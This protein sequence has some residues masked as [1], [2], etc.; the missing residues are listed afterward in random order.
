[1]LEVLDRLK[2]TVEDFAARSDKL[3]EEFRARIDRERQ[4][5]EAALAEQTQQ[6]AAASSAADSALQTALD[7]AESKFERRKSVIGKAY[8]A[9][10][11]Q[12]LKDIEKKTGGRKYELQKTMLQAERDRETGLATTHTTLQEFKANLATEQETL[13]ALEKAAHRAFRGY[14]KFLR[15]LTQAREKAAPDLSLDESQLLGEL[16]ELRELLAKSR[17][18]LERFRRFRLLRIFKSLAVW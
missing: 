9:S 4:Q 15:L 14:R 8:Q 2:R 5:R 17:G 6:V 11:E 1:M 13:A 18:E 10:K 12:G 16:R 7:N 3:N